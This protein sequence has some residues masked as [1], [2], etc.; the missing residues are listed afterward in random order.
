MSLA[1]ASYAVRR[2]D[3]GDQF[4]YEIQKVFTTSCALQSPLPDD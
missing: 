1:M 3:A 4:I 2:R